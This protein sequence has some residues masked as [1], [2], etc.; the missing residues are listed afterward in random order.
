MSGIPLLPAPLLQTC[1]SSVASAEQLL[2]TLLHISA[3]PV[4]LPTGPLSQC[5]T[6]LAPSCEPAGLP[7]E[8]CEREDLTSGQQGTFVLGPTRTPDGEIMQYQGAVTREAQT[9]S[10]HL[11]YDRLPLVRDLSC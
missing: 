4:A 5:L 10:G 2:D 3:G 9:A 11:V 6:R 8:D 7:Q 1:M